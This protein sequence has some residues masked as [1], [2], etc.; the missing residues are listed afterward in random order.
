MNSLLLVWRFQE[1]GMPVRTQIHEFC[2]E[3]GEMSVLCREVASCLEIVDGGKA[4]YEG[5]IGDLQGEI[6]RLRSELKTANESLDFWI[7]R[8]SGPLMEAAV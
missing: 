6:L 4:F 2:A 7:G 1:K 8:R 5:I 3:P